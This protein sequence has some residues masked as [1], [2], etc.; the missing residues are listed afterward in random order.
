MDPAPDITYS[1]PS[2]Y[3]AYTIVLTTSHH[4]LCPLFISH[5]G[6]FTQ[7]SAGIHYI[8]EFKEGKFHG[9]GEMHWF[10]DKDQRK[11]YIGEFKQGTMEGHG[12]M[13]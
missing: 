8:G 7:E 6:E 13:K 5:S 12:E 1:Y 4:V 9:Q 11:K 10:F 3:K 2:I